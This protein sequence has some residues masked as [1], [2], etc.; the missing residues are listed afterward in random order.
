[1]VGVEDSFFDLG[2]DS[3]LAVAL[4]GALRGAGLDVAVRDIFEYRTVAALCQFL[5]GRPAVAETE[6]AVR[7]F[8][9]ISDIYREALGDGIVDAYPAAQAQLG[10]LAEMM[11]DDSRNP[12]HNCTSFRILDDKRFQLHALQRAAEVVVARHEALRTSF[13]LTGFP[14]PMQ[15]VHATAQL[16]VGSRSLAGLPDAEVR[17]ALRDFMAQERATLFHLDR[18]PLLR[19]FAHACDGCWWLSITEC[20]AIIEGWSH[21]S[22]LMEILDCYSRLRDGSPEA[23][24]DPPPTRYADFV[25]AELRSLES[26]ADRGYWQQIVSRYPKFSLPEDWGEPGDTAGRTHRQWIALHDLDPALRNLAATA[27]VPLKAVLHAAHLKVLSQLTDEPRFCAG[28]VCNGRPERTGAD[29][30]YGLHLNSL[31]FP[32]DRSARTWLELVQHVFAREVE[33]WPHRRFPLAV[34]QRELGDGHRLLDAR[35][36]YQDFRQVDTSIVDYDASIDDSP[37]E[38]PLGVSARAGFLV[39]TAN[40]RVISKANA[41]RLADM[42]RAVLEAMAADAGGDAQASYLPP[43]ERRRLLTEWSSLARAWD[44]PG[45]LDS[46]DRQ[47]AVTPDA[48][49]VTEPGSPA[50]TYR[51]LAARVNQLAHHL[52]AHGAAAESVIGVLLD[53]GAGLAAALLG[54][55]KSG[56]G[57]LPIDPSYPAERIAG[58]LADAGSRL[59]VTSSR[60]ADRFAGLP[61]IETVLLDRDFDQIGARPDSPPPRIANPDGLAYV[62]FT[63]GSTGRPKGVQVSHQA[64]AN[65]VAWAARELAGH[66][67]GGAPLFSSIAFDL[68]VPNLWAPLVTGQRVHMVPQDTDPADLGAALSDAAPFSFIKLTPGH[69][70]F[71]EAQLGAGRA[72]ALAPRIV[73]A[74]EALPGSLANRWL[75]LLGAGGLINEYGPTEATVGT[76]TFPVRAEQHAGTVPIGFPL[77]GMIM[78]VLDACLQPAPAGVTGELYVGGTGVARGYAGR[79]ELTAQRFVPDP[80]GPPG[81]RLYRTGDLARHRPDGAVEFRGRTD[82]QVKIRGYR[83]EPGE[84]QAVLASHPAVRETVATIRTTA[85]GDRQLI[86]YYVQ[87][88]EEVA[89]EELARHCSAL[90]PDYM[91]PAAFVPLPALPL[92][93]NGKIDRGALPDPDGG[94]A[95]KQAAHVP[96]RT[97]LEAEIAAVWRETLALD[98]VGVIESFFDIGGHSIRAISVIGALRAAGHEVAVKDILECQTVASLAERI[99]ARAGS[100][101]PD[102][103]AAV[104]P[105]ALTSAADR[106]KLP[107]GIIDAYP[108]SQV[109]LGMLVV[110]LTSGDASQN[111]Y[112]NFSAF[113]IR[114]RR[115]LAEQALQDA[116]HIVIA[117]HDVLRTSFELTGF[118]VPMQLVHAAAEAP[119]QVRDLRGSD[120][121][122]QRQAIRELAA[123]ERAVLFDLGAAPLMRVTAVLESDDSWWLALTMCHAIIEGWSHHSLLMEVL[124]C[125]RQIRD[126]GE[127]A[128]AAPLPVRYADFI[129]GELAALQSPEDRQ[130]WQGIVDRYPPLELPA[131]WGDVPGCPRQPVRAT[132]PLRDIEEALRAAAKDAGVPL[133]SVLFAAHL[134]VLSQLTGQ[135]E[136]HSG[137]LC[138]GRPEVEGADRVYGMHLNTLPFGY[139]RT[140]RTWRDLVRQVFDREIAMWPHRV[141]PMPQ[142]QRMAGG[143]RLVEAYFNY[144]D[145]GIVDSSRVDTDAAI[146][147]ARTEFALHVSTLGGNLSITTH[148]HVLSQPNVLRIAAMH[149]LV[150]ESIAAGLDG[151]ATE[152]YLPRSE[153]DEQMVEWNDTAVEWS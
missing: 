57:Y 41:A 37:T 6:P 39:L 40:T 97:P 29:R 143:R 104:E 54:T 119:F 115:P 67:T 16:P 66:G 8:E 98:R 117:R 58:M 81:A 43:D 148:N 24:W 139:D 18:P 132:V 130:Y 5:A 128:P 56:G 121:R 141:F 59:V 77:P 38:F 91:M 47:A 149:R 133:K 151:D 49:A 10:M 44:G 140:A 145:F 114:D 125:Y 25:A 20:H 87:A 27:R 14:V 153:Q 19:L 45:V 50:V 52:R 1:R 31:P 48:A 26:A 127:P 109:Q 33:L 3:I 135:P 84:V 102:D 142:I 95:D 116:I 60:Y 122:A 76:C 4:V 64:L 108:V 129:A 110:M 11:S 131:G 146:Y 118:S 101:A 36:S 99:A 32:F 85:A 103:K 126:H 30:V 70:E 22:L 94:P 9:L 79:P 15:I 137:L 72:A 113:R 147:E 78:Y 46:F 134:K 138:H 124:D 150:L 152:A 28:L 96:P 93:A 123:A 120:A 75:A 65:H 55:W 73:V 61:G 83:I 21:H 86:A 2:G 62:V 69:L 63:S 136:F 13:V 53:R 100:P 34:I 106:A 112:H 7:P 51:S 35:F 17:Q 92:N 144:L 105:F 111:P 74:G 80:Y 71:L 90:L 23:P 42:Y 82:D 89:E 68:A 107:D 88:A 12:Y